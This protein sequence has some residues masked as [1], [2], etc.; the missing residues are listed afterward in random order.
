MQQIHGRVVFSPTDLTKHLA[1]PHITT[2]DLAAA[3]AGRAEGASGPDDALQLVFRK[4]LEHEAGYLAGLR[5]AGLEVAEIA[6][7]FDDAGRRAAESETLAAMRRGVQVVYQATLYDGQWGGQADFLLRRERPSALGGWS[8]DI[9]DTKLARRLKVP[10]LLQMATYA[11]RLA[12]VQ[13]APV[14]VLTVVT[15]DGR[16][17]GWRLEDV[18]SYARRARS[19]LMA[20]VEQA[21]PTESAPVRQCGQCRWEQLCRTGWER[22]DDLSLVAGMPARHRLTLREQGI[23]TVA[24][25]AAANPDE[26][27]GIA[28]PARDRLTQQAR[29]QARERST[30]HPAYELAEPVVG[31]GLLRLPAPSPGDLYLDFEGDPFAGPAGREYL[32]GLWDRHSRYTSWWAHTDAEER[33]LTERLVDEL[34]ARWRACPGLHVYHYAPY[35]LSALKRLTGRHGTREAELDA[36]LRAELFVDLYAVVRQGVRI[37]K[38]SYSIKKL[39]DFYWGGARAVTDGSVADAMTSVV[40][41]ERF[42]VDGDAAVLR[43]IEEYNRDDVRSTH[44]LHSWLEERRAELE[45]CYGPHDRFSPGVDERGAPATEVEAAELV[46]ADRLAD[47]GEPL[48]AGLVGW[49]RREERPAWWEFFGFQQLDDDQLVAHP[50]AA[51]RVGRPQRVG[52]SGRSTVWRYPFP[53]QDCKFPAR[54]YLVDVDSRRPVGKL[55]R[56]DPAGGFVDVSV[57]NGRDPLVVRGLQPQGPPNSDVLRRAIAHVANELLAGRD[58]LGRRLLDR[59]VPR[60]L[61]ARPGE[62]PRQVVLRAGARL[63]AAVLAVQGP[64][65]SGKTTVAAELVRGLLDAGLT[66]GVTAQS[67]AVVTNLLQTVDRPAV[68]KCDAEEFSGTDPV[69]SV[70]ANEPVV[71][72][73]RSRAV[74]LVGGSAWLWSREDVR[75]LVDVLVIDEAGQFSLANAVAVSTAAASLVLLGDP[76]Q[77]M[78]PTQAVHPHGAGVSAL[79]HLIGDHDTIPADRGVFLDT[80]WRMHPSIADFVS[81]TSY[82]GRLQAGPGRLRQRVDAPGVLQGSGLR[83]VPVG[84]ASNSSASAEE[85]ETVRALVEDLLDGGRWTDADGVE[86]PLRPADVLVVT[87]YN[88][89]VACL[90]E[91]LPEGVQAGTVDKF[92]GREAPV[93]V[94]STASST[95]ADAPRGVDFLFDLHRLNVAVSRARALTVLVGSPQL[96]DAEVHTPEQ[97]RKVNA[98]CRYVELAEEVTAARGAPVA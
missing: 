61:S 16:E 75:G 76:Q 18:A 68:Q 8:Y 72:A 24:Q 37:S 82:D 19:R 10:A 54:R 35:E 69:L 30:G 65:G 2:L 70:A 91:V 41:Y 90:R 26:L 5:E 11:E 52:T 87:P 92:Q 13:G 62:T 78:S 12:Q 9:A 84:H 77:L 97:L 1:C 42:L 83:W 57:G 29:L 22:A 40:E 59:R 94:Y 28:R 73:L 38:P 53:P 14:Q 96:L 80:T 3:R 98:L 43:R 71:A 34:T 27:T 6:T 23:T 33:V 89:Q 7:R 48:L 81:A 67:H 17:H 50:N 93:V 85:A 20:A 31:H 58:T 86:R 63:D 44:D 47:A 39:E 32:A 55:V 45:H 79:Q 25:L 66:V 64:P 49:H 95:A 15:G 74:N 56:Y 4:G 88:R 60:Q 46:L 36:M 21:T 51:G